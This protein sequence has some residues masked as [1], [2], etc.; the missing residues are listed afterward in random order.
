MR[1]WW[2]SAT[3]LFCDRATTSV[4]ASTD[5]LEKEDNKKVNGLETLINSENISFFPFQRN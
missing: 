2:G 4:P 5:F 3:A 1:F